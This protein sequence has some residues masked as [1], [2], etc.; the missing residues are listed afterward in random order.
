[1]LPLAIGDTRAMLRDG[2]WLPG[3]GSIAVTVGR[4]VFPPARKLAPDQFL[5]AL[6]LRDAARV[7]ILAH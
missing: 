5:A 7:Y 2:Q 6:A 3:E 1:V 4:P